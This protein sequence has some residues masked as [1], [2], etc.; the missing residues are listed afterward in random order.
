MKMKWRENVNNIIMYLG[1][2]DKRSWMLQKI[3]FVW[4]YMFSSIDILQKLL[5]IFFWL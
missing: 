2:K 1:H 3:F 5:E 4:Y